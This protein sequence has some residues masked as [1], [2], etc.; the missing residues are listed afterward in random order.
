MGRDRLLWSVYAV[1]ALTTIF[2]ATEQVLLVLL[3][4]VVVWLVKAPPGRV[5]ARGRARRVACLA[6][7]SG[8]Q[9]EATAF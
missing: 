3:A 1:L 5:W 7:V 6:S 8:G 4:G 2:T 9:G